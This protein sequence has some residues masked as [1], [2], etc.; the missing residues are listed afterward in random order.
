MARPY[1]DAHQH[2]IGIQKWITRITFIIFAVLLLFTFFSINRSNYNEIK[3]MTGVFLPL[4]SGWIGA[5][6]AFYFSKELADSLTQQ[7]NKLRVEKEESTQEVEGYTRDFE[8][9]IKERDEKFKKYV[10]FLLAE[11][12]L[13]KKNLSLGLKIQFYS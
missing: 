4:L 13:L 2:T 10:A 8:E 3:E 11:N 7:I 1:K 6:V 12:A 5:I 9:M